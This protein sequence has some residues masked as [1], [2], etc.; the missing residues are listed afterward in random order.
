MAGASWFTV[1]MRQRVLLKRLLLIPGGRCGSFGLRRRL[2]RF[3]LCFRELFL[4]QRACM[5]L[6]H[7]LALRS[8]PQDLSYLEIRVTESLDMEER[9]K[10]NAVIMN[11]LELICQA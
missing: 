2:K 10:Q 3:C 11:I 4:N 5:D 6:F 8:R 7:L 9:A 1:H